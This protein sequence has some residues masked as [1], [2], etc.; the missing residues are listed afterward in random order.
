MSKLCRSLTGTSFAV[1][2]TL[3]S[4]AIA[5]GQETPVPVPVP[6][7]EPQAE[8]QA[9]MQPEA[10]EAQEPVI[11]QLS[12]VGGAEGS[13]EATLSPAAGDQAGAVIEVQGLEPAQYSAFLVA[14]TCDSPGDVV[15]PLGTVEVADQGSGRGEVALTSPLGALTGSEAT[16]QVH[17]QGDAPTQ[18]LLCGAVP[19]AG[20]SLPAF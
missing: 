3:G 20:A 9:E 12:A 11:V 14:G 18:A 2:L 6:D 15:A 7:Q 5:S 1:M 13:G 4:A 10:Q 17:P 8:A 16:V 19:A